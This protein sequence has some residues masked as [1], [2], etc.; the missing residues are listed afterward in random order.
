MLPVSYD[1][2]NNPSHT[3]PMIWPKMSTVL[4]WRNSDGCFFP[5]S[6]WALTPQGPRPIS[7]MG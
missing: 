5:F 2:R 7:G 6:K 3:E 1:A 4:L